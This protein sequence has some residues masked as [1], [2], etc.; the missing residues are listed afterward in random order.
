MVISS[1]FKV[2]STI[3]RFEDLDAWKKARLLCNDIFELIESDFLKKDFSLQNQMNR[4]SGSIMDNIAEGYE[5]GGKKE[6][7]QFLSIA[8]GHAENYGHNYSVA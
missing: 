1:K 6:F 8:K 3:H 2:M 7:I 5:R 4:S